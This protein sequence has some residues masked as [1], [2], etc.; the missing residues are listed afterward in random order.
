[1]ACLRVRGQEA[2]PLRPRLYR[3]LRHDQATAPPVETV[4][5]IPSEGSFV[6]APRAHTLPAQKGMELRTFFVQFPWEALV[7]RCLKND[8]MN[9]PAKVVSAKGFFTS[10]AKRIAGVLISLKDF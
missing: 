8:T 7:K 1:V 2:S 6:C 9:R 5:P 10:T 3:V 4:A